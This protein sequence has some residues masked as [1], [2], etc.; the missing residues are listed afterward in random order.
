MA[1]TPPTPPTS[2]QQKGARLDS[3]RDAYVLPGLRDER[4]H[5]PRDPG[6]S[7][8]VEAGAPSQASS[9]APTSR[10]CCRTRA[11]ARA[12]RSS[13]TSSAVPPPR[14]GE[15]RL[16]REEGVLAQ[17]LDALPAHRRAGQ[18]RIRSMAIQQPPTDT[19]KRASR[20]HDG[21]LADDL[22]EEQVDFAPNY[23]D[24]L[25]GAWASLSRQQA[26]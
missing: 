8:R 23:D 7:R 4:H 25:E 5:R 24:R 13:E 6:R 14:G 22:A 21:A 10:A 17:D 2:P 3:R 1:A 18:L 9:T 19:P 11:T 20:S 12:P 16:R 15:L 26:H